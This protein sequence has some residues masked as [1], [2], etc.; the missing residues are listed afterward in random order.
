MIR[1]VDAPA[2]DDGVGQAP[3]DMAG[4]LPFIGRTVEYRP[5]ESL[6]VERILDLA[7]DLHLA[8]HAF[9]HAPGVKPLSACLPVLPMTLSLEA[10]AEAAA[11]LAP[12][13]G[14]I[15]AAEAKASRWIELA[16]VDRLALRIV[17]RHEAYD[18]SRDVHQIRAAIQ[19]DGAPAPAVTA[20]F[21]FSKRYR[22]DLAFTLSAFSRPHPHALTG[23]EIY[24]ERLLFHGPAYQC[25]AGPIT[26]AD[27]GVACEMRALSAAGLF[28]SNARP[29]L[30][31][32]PQ[33]LDG[34][35]QLIGVWAMARERYVFPIGLKRLE[36]YRPSPAAGTRL[37]VRIDITSDSGKT[38]EANIEAQDGAGGV[39]MR[40]EGWRMW[41]FRWDRRFVDFRRAPAREALSDDYAL[42]GFAGVCRMIRLSDV[43]DFDLALLARHYLHVEEMPAFTQK[44]GAPRRQRQWLLGRVAAKDAV[45]AWLKR[46]GAEAI[47]PAA[48]RIVH[49]ESRQPVIRHAALPDARL[50]KISIAHCDDRAIAAA[51]QEPVG[52]DIEPVAPRD[53]AF[54]ETL[55]APAERLLLD[56]RAK[57]CDATTDEWMTRL[58]CAKEA[59]GKHRGSGVDGAVRKLAAIAISADGAIDI[60][61]RGEA[62]SRRVT[63]L[64]DGDVIIAW[65]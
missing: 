41:K 17:A 63:T 52:I 50:P 48:L 16:D 51:H 49:D 60:L 34:I 32:D 22:L 42:E 1:L 27:E 38:L 62:H 64:R 15:G 65:T 21:F 58:W 30:L 29:Q 54:C 40:I 20:L 10:M 14:L 59:L 55:C 11:C 4:A 56:E 35:G 57:A 8:D 61:P 19:P 2:A 26:L 6:V 44:A 47:H 18:A 53:A 24:R 36:L 46:A 39:W 43:S 37:P 9:V 25:L 3:D 31:L 45:R 5:G 13:Y 28:R 33:I 23:E 7:E 12:G